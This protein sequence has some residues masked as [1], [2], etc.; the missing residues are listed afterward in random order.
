[1]SEA[2]FG[3]TK[4]PTE[5]EY[6]AALK[7]VLAEHARFL[8]SVDQ[9]L[10]TE[11]KEGGPVINGEKVLGLDIL[12]GND[13]DIRTKFGR[14]LDLSGQNLAQAQFADAKFDITS[15]FDR[16]T[17]EETVFEGAVF[18]G[19]R[20]YGAIID[21][22]TLE[23]MQAVRPASTPTGTQVDLGSRRGGPKG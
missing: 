9:C 17:F 15:Y 8:S 10:D 3:A 12:F 23:E 22:R 1:M 6:L 4:L 20:F 2:N 18:K 11:N 16:A 19:A 21:G 5:E 14:P 7:M 13:V